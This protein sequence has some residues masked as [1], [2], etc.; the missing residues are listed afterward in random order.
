MRRLL[1][2]FSAII[3]FSQASVAQNYPTRPITIIVPF[4]AGGSMEFL[5]RT[6]QPKMEAELGQPLIFENKPGA[7]G[8][9]GSAYVAKAEPDGYTLLLIGLNLGVQPHLFP[10]LGFDPIKDFVAIGGLADNP[11]VCVVSANSKYKTIQD[12]L[13]DARER[14]E[15]VTY[16]SPGAGSPSH[17]LAAKMARINNVKMT[18]VPYKGSNPGLTDLMG[19]FV[20][21]FC[22]GAANVLA[23]VNDG[24]LRPL[25]VIDD[26]RSR[27]LPDVP[28]LKE[29]GLGEMD[30][31]STYILLAPAKTPKPIVDRLSSVL[32]KALSDKAVENVFTKGGFN[33]SH[34]TAAEM[35]KLFKAQYDDWGPVVKELGLAVE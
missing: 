16:A 5:L 12:L 11:N 26:K 33:P 7:T 21:M 27:F 32:E 24:K 17:L 1:L 9:I 22:L 35:S 13:N 2:A 31:G 14:P 4:S 23:L 20:D 6:I 15:K 10:K 3:A 34:A 25:V 30:G 8:N 18:H 28:T 19:G 29:L